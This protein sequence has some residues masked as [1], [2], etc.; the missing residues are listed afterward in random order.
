MIQQKGD[1]THAGN[2][3][4]QLGFFLMLP[5]ASIATHARYKLPVMDSTVS[6]IVKET[7]LTSSVLCASLLVYIYTHG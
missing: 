5:F 1:L 6:T 2:G 4:T 3:P 7:S